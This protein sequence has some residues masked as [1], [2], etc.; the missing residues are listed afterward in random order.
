MCTQKMPRA[1]RSG[2]YACERED[3]GR[4]LYKRGA[5]HL[6]VKTDCQSA[7]RKKKAK[8]CRRAERE[9]VYTPRRVEEKRSLAAVGR[10]V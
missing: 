7:A 2:K 4:W 5:A 8:K 1:R 3:D 6:A 10:Y 9:D